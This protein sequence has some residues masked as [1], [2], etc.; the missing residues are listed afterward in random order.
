MFFR[1][2]IFVPGKGI[3]IHHRDLR[4]AGTS[5]GPSWTG[6]LRPGMMYASEDTARWGAG[7]GEG[8]WGRLHPGMMYASEDMAR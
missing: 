2:A 7:G 6:R 1:N 8:G 3:I 5:R 4:C